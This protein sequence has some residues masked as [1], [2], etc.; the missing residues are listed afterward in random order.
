M[1]HEKAVKEGHTELEKNVNKTHGGG[2]ALAAEELQQKS[3]EKS[4]KGIATQS[5]KE[6]KKKPVK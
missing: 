1:K 3:R 4:H 5:S 2:A 6:G